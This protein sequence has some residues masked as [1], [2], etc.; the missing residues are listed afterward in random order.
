MLFYC[1]GYHLKQQP[2]PTKYSSS[3]GNCEYGVHI[4]LC[5]WCTHGRQ[6]WHCPV[7]YAIGCEVLPVTAGV[8]K[9]IVADVKLL[10]VHSTWR[11][12]RDKDSE[13]AFFIA[14]LLT[15]S[16]HQGPYSLVCPLSLPVSVA[17][18]TSTTSP[19]ALNREK[20]SG[21]IQRG[22]AQKGEIKIQIL[23]AG[24]LILI[25]HHCWS[26]HCQSPT[27]M[28]VY[29]SLT[30]ITFVHLLPLGN[31]SAQSCTK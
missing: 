9:T 20:R 23:I 30:I 28:N 16:S 26:L 3:K 14:P 6:L 1:Q 8:G 24:C 5:I 31:R 2:L 25:K 15:I 13:D 21:D 10:N 7:N 18:Y 19:L 11:K 27:V 22:N 17:L 4:E 12:D 29:F